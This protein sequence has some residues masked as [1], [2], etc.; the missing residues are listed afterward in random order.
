[1]K[2]L[3]VIQPFSLREIVHSL[4]VVQ[5]FAWARPES[6]ITWLV[7]EEYEE[8]VRASPF[9]RETIVVPRQAGWGAF[10]A[11]RRRLKIRLFDAV[12]DMA[13]VLRSGLLTSAVLALE[14]WGRA[15]ARPGAGFFCNRRIAPPAGPGPH[16]AL[17]I[18]QPF[19]RAA[20]VP[21]RLYFPL[22][23]KPGGTF[24]WE[25]FFSGDPRNTFVL[26]NDGRREAKGWPYA[27]ELTALIFDQIPDSR[28]AWCAAAKTQPSCVVSAARFLNVTGC[29]LGEMV[30]LLR[31]PAT[32]IG[33]DSGLMQISAASGNPVLALFGTSDPRQ[34]GPYPLDAAKHNVVL[35]PEGQLAKLQPRTVLAAL[36]ELRQRSM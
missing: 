36:E 13:G 22:E 19:L 1:M 30:S 14:K 35:A 28:I 15:D 20:G 10:F 11:L 31:K 2:S 29:P 33:I 12:W 17:D 5:S 7:S 24:G 8:L 4:Q 34:T 27:N 23:F 16:H 3:L 25:E 26:F 6:R 21:Q 18:L 32:F 9:V